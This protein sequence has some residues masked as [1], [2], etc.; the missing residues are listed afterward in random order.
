MCGVQLH[1]ANSFLSVLEV[2]FHS[3]LTTATRRHATGRRLRGNI[4]P[5]FGAEAPCWAGVAVE[6]TGP[7]RRVSSGVDSLAATGGSDWKLQPATALKALVPPLI[8]RLTCHSSV[9]GRG[10]AALPPARE[11]TGPRLG[12]GPKQAQE[13]EFMENEDILNPLQILNSLDK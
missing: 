3:P 7:C 6:V 13:D 2:N 12:K 8:G 9:P 10:R 5:V 1:P 11:K 4:S